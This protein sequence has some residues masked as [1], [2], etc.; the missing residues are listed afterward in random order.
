MVVKPEV[1]GRPDEETGSEDES[2][3]ELELGILEPV[4]GELLIA[5]GS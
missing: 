1:L 2:P 3:L 5:E 4:N